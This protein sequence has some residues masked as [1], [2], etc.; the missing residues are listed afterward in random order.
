MVTDKRIANRRTFL[1]RAGGAALAFAVPAEALTGAA[2]VSSSPQGGDGSGLLTDTRYAEGAAFRLREFVNR[3]ADPKASEEILR[4]LTSL[5]A[6]P[7]AAAWSELGARAEES[8]D[9]LERQGKKK[10]A[11]DAYNKAVLYY[12]VAK[13]PVLNH[14]AKQASYRKCIAAFQK[15]IRYWDPPVERVA[16][17]FEHG[18][19]IGY[20]R[21]PKGVDRPAVVIATGGVD[22]YKEER[23]N[24][25]LLHAGMAA[26]GIDMPGNGECPVWYTADAERWY[27]AA[28]D[29]L[30]TRPD[31]DPDRIGLI[32][33]SYGGYWGAKMAYVEPQRLKACVQ[34]G[35]PIHHTFQEPWLRY[36]R[37]EKLY[38]WSL[39]DSMIYANHVKDYDELVRTAPAL[40]LQQQG[41]LEKPSA[42]MLAVNGDKDPWISIDDVYLLLK[43]GEPKSARVFA[44]ATHMGRGFP[45]GGGNLVMG[46]LKRQLNG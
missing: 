36:L 46:W 34:W 22:V 20:L 27:K 40:S 15:A 29:Y 39:L 41:W 30:Q 19:M 25:D 7:W 6:E 31:L 18:Q 35:G 38:L 2:D 8:G 3:G 1:Q 33:R 44:N 11:G 42:P 12:G 21:K 9:Q 26:F 14:P 45:G 37:A 16:I 13:F 4:R 32:G 23:D 5:D 10:E 43:T 17:P 24:A 28:I